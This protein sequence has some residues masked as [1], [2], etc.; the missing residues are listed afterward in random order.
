MTNR[1]DTLELE[2]R[3][4]IC[5]KDFATKIENQQI[6]YELNLKKF[7]DF[8]KLIDAQDRKKA[9][10]EKKAKKKARKN[11]IKALSKAI[12]KINFKNSINPVFQNSKI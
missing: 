6:S 8:K 2:A 4:K 9:K 11:E 1:V 3:M 12:D 10:V 5:L 7:K